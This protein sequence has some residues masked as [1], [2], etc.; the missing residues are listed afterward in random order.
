MKM[1]YRE[2]MEQRLNEQTK[3]AHAKAAAKAKQVCVCKVCKPS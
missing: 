3:A 1:T 2:E